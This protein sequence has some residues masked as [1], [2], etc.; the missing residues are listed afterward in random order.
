MFSKQVH[1]SI[2][3]EIFRGRYTKGTMQS[4]SLK[5]KAR[6]YNKIYQILTIMSTVNILG[7][8]LLLTKIHI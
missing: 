2:Q 6:N 5:S 3:N 1:F 4:S 8:H 7:V